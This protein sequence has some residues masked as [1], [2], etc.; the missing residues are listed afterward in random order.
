M[1]S[2][3]DH[4]NFSQVGYIVKDIETA[5]QSYAKL[6]GAELPPTQPCGYGAA[7]T[8]YKGVP[9]PDSHCKL[10]FFDLTPGVQLELIEPD[11]GPSTWREYLDANGEGVHHIAFN[12]TDMD[13]VIAD[14]VAE[15]MTVVQQGNYDNN[16]G[17]YTYLDGYEKFKCVIELLESF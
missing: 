13:K 16:T 9:V 14:C 15:G 8:V 17:R 12:V 10:A 5:K 11:E 6:L 2:V 7:N 4:L 3:L 1:K